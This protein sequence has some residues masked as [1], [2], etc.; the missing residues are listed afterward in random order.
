MQRNDYYWIEVVTFNHIIVYEL[1]DL[2]E[3]CT[4]KSFKTNK[5]NAMEHWKYSYFYNQI[6]TNESNFSIE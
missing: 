4:N 6:L 2:I 5:K 3:M 1:L